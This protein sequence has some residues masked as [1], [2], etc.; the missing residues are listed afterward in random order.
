MQSSR[1]V[2]NTMIWWLRKIDEMN[3]FTNTTT[4]KFRI[5]RL[6]FFLDLYQHKPLHLWLWDPTQRFQQH[7]LSSFWLQDYPWRFKSSTI[8]DL[9]AATSDLPDLMIWERL[10][11]V[12]LKEEWT[13]PFRSHKNTSKV[14]QK[15]WKRS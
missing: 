5:H 13:I 2:N 10:P 4:F 12:T 3:Y 11:K 6:L 1:K 9:D 8:V 15:F 14:S 7:K